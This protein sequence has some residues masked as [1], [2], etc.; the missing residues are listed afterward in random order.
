VLQPFVR[1]RLRRMADGVVHDVQQARFT[2]V[3]R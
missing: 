3:N 2:H 1:Q